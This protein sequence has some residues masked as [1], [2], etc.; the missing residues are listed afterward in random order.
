MEKYKFNGDIKVLCVKAASFP[1][2]VAAAYEQ[3]HALLNEKDKRIFFGISYPGANGQIIY[4]AAASENYEGEAAALNME[5]FTIKKGCYNSIVI[6]DFMKNIPAVGKAFSQLLAQPDIDPG[7]YCLEIYE[8]KNDI[9]CLVPLK[10][11]I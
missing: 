5:Q 4:K 9:R 1:A 3:L 6:K 2:G 8:G 10:N 11:L 7:G